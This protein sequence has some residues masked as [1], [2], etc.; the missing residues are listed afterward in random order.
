MTQVFH[1]ATNTI[2]RISI[3]LVAMLLAASGW[4][5]GAIVRSPYATQVDVVRDQPIPFSHKHHVQ[6]VGIDCRYCHTSVEVSASAGMPS[7]ETCMGCHSQIW[8]D[9]PMLEPVRASFRDDKP[10][11]WNRVHDLPDFSYFDHSIHVAKGIG[12]ST[13][14]GRVDEMPLMWQNATLHMDWCLDCHRNPARYIRPRDEVFTMEWPPSEE[15]TGLSGEELVR[16]HG[17]ENGTK[18]SNCST[19]HR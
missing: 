13:C 14:H 4:L 18:L 1:P 17:I 19:C 8:A 2:S 12:C 5:I 16:L 10:I 3:L 15:K 9:S 7:T 11:R 6:Q